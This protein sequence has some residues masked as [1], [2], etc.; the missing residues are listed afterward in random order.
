[1]AEEFLDDQPVGGLGSI[2]TEPTKKVEE[3]A[4]VRATE[5]EKKISAAQKLRDQNLKLNAQI[6]KLMSS[7]DNRNLSPIN[8]KYLAMAEGFLAPT[9]TGGFGESAGAAAGK[10]R[11]VAGEERKRLTE[12]EK[13]KLEFMI[14][15]YGLSQKDYELQKK[16]EGQEF[17]RDYFGKSKPTGQINTAATEA[18]AASGAPS[19]QDM[20]GK[21]QSAGN[22][23]TITL[24][25]I[26]NAPEEAR[27]TLEKLY[28]NQ[29]NALKIGQGEFGA[30]KTFLP[31]L[32]EST[33]TLTVE[34]AR[35]LSAL[36]NATRGLPTDQKNKYF[37]EWY[38]ENGLIKGPASGAAH[39]YETEDIETPQ[40]KQ[41]RLK[42]SEAIDTE[43]GKE[44]VKRQAADITAY[45]D[46]AKLGSNIAISAKQM[47]DYASDPNLEGMFGLLAKKG[48]TN[49]FFTAMKEP[50]KIGS[51]SI[52]VGNIEDVIRTAG[53]TDEQIA[54]AAA[55]KKPASE[56]E[57]AFTRIYLAK[58]GAITEGERAIVR[59][60]MPSMSD[61][62]KIV[63]L[64]SEL[65][66]A[67]AQFDQQKADL[68]NAYVNK[69]PSATAFDFEHDA[70]SPYKSLLKNYA[71]HTAEISNE[72]MPGAVKDPLKG[73]SSTKDKARKGSSLWNKV[74]EQYKE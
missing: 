18:T 60:I 38:A 62:A 23:R 44:T 12:A 2:Q 61:P 33:D 26:A 28:D 49:A 52:G 47:Y 54:A 35:E 10:Y 1:M 36:K 40:Q 14:Q 71:E 50:V 37:M 22:I 70:S 68:F 31:V 17:M 34:Q 21:G 72:Y 13:T 69:N 16:I 3:E 63:R 65:M 5:S 48:M 29:Q 19:L 30:T 73:V 39:P 9:K 43:R 27:P 74:Q 15:Q 25:D 67:R 32:N 58:Q 6:E 55:F 56:S 53:G 59:N 42:I 11:E 66:I 57:L 20:I 7:L 45:N 24:S 41:K 8:E 46:E 51:V 64:K 4:P